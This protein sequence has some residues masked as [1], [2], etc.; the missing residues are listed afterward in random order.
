MVVAAGKAARANRA[1]N[2][3]VIKPVTDSFRIP[4]TSSGT[5]STLFAGLGSAT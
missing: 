5:Q 2:V 4:F 1:T 3:T